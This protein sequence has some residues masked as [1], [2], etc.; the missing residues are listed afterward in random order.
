MDEDE[1]TQLLDMIDDLDERL[2]PSNRVE[3]DEP[4]FEQL[5][6]EHFNRVP[7][8]YRTAAAPTYG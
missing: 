5:R 7:G 1:Y 3:Y 8:C 6:D 4:I 2:G